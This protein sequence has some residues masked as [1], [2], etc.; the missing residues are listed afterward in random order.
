MASLSTQIGQSLAKITQRDLRVTNCNG[1]RSRR[2]SKNYHYSFDQCPG[3]EQHTVPFIDTWMTKASDR[4]SSDY[5]WWFKQDLHAQLADA[6]ITAFLPTMFE[7]LMSLNRTIIVNALHRINMYRCSN[8]TSSQTFDN[9]VR[10]ASSGPSKLYPNAPPHII[11]PGY[12]YDVEYIRHYTGINPI[13]LP[14]SLLSVLKFAVGDNAYSGENGKFILNAY[15]G[16]LNGRN[17]SNLASFLGNTEKFV[18]PANYE[19]SD[20]L[21]YRAAVVLPYSITNTKS[22]EQYELNIPIFAPTPEYAVNL[23]LFYD[24]LA[25]AYPYCESFDHPEPHKSSPY[26]FNPNAIKSFEDDLFWISFSEIYL[27][28]CVEYFSSAKELQH[29]LNTYTSETYHTISKCMERANKWRKYEAESN[30]CS[31]LQ[32]VETSSRNRSLTAKTYREALQKL[33]NVDKLAV[34]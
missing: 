26:E 19:L 8:Q 21:K 12:V 18:T 13:F 22:L 34:G 11:A 6:H 9:L 23:H 5:F 15:K 16:D 14:F 32:Q 29:K 30:L 20:L 2:A 31:V 3:G 33:Y 24:R 28:P 4:T 7:Y 10:L 17:D 27:W 1:K 25:T